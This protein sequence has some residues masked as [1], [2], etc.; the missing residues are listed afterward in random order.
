M[1]D[2]SRRGRDIL[3]CS[4]E[5]VSP[6]NLKGIIGRLPVITR[7]GTSKWVV[8]IRL[9][10]LLNNWWRGALFHHLHDPSNCS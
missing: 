9:Y 6:A 3:E 1:V 8:N 5:S 10:L 2:R 4:R 7:W